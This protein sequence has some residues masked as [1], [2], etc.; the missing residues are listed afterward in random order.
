VIVVDDG[1]TDGTADAVHKLAPSLPSTFTFI[2][3]SNG[4]EA[5]ARNFGVAAAAGEFIA[6]LDQDDVWLPDK[7]ERQLPLFD[8]PLRPSLVFSAYTRV[9]GQTRTLVRLDSWEPTPEHA[10]RQLM[11]GCCVTPS[12]AVVRRSALAEIGPFDESLWL[13]NDWDMWL[14]LAANRQP[15][16]YL[17]EPL[18][19]YLWHETN[20]SRDQRKIADAALFIF[21]RLFASGTIP[22]SLK[23]CEARCMA[24]WHLNA[25]CAAFAAGDH[26]SAR[27]ALRNAIKAH[28][29]S[30]RPGWL[31]LYARCLTVPKN[32][33]RQIADRVL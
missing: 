18:T 22:D 9:S 5:S 16:A 10:L 1:C 25:A 24:R 7:L 28:P 15:F 4:G 17:R 33:K 8:S 2:Q 26:A 12:T 27:A 29:Q 3:K 19:D 14:R 30:G 13:G 21:P 31:L 6:F 32:P 11:D 20:M 23:G